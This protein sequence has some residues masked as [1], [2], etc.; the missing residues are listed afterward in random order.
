MKKILLMIFASICA[1]CSFAQTYDE[2]DLLGK[3]NVT[4]ITGPVNNEIISFESLY[5]GDSL[6][7][8]EG[9]NWWFA[10]GYFTKLKYYYGDGDYYDPQEIITDA[11][12]PVW[13]FHIS[14]NNKLH[15]Q[16]QWCMNAIR[17]VIKEWTNGVM[18]LESYDG[19]T[20]IE[21]KKD[22]SAVQAVMAEIPCDGELYDIQGHKATRTEK[23][24]I[25]IRNNRK[26][27]A[28]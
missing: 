11:I 18:K 25:Y 2:T 20:K 3:W 14:N 7:T 5:L 6:V 28:Q 10:A 21:L 26:F 19:K 17:L 27:I 24:S 15:I 4:S 16:C 1:V 13:D 12:V 23:G 8:G 9:D 22:Q